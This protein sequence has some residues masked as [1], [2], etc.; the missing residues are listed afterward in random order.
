MGGKKAAFHHQMHAS[1]NWTIKSARERKRKTHTDWWYIYSYIVYTARVLIIYQLSHLNIS[2]ERAHF[3]LSF[4]SCNS[5]IV[6][7]ILMNI[8]LNACCT[9]Y[10][11][12]C[13]L[14]A[15]VIRRGDSLY[16]SIIYICNSILLFLFLIPVFASAFVLQSIFNLNFQF[17]QMDIYTHLT[18]AKKLP[19]NSHIHIHNESNWKNNINAI[20]QCDIIQL[21]FANG[22]EIYTSNIHSSPFRECVCGQMGGWPVEWSDKNSRLS[23]MK[24]HK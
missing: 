6:I 8:L 23:K 13:V 3:S 14:G 24:I 12:S 9:L 20:K 21:Q 10:V 19:S 7:C 4:Y 22:I 11:S 15:S 2:H 18:I 1:T 5:V 16:T 17:V